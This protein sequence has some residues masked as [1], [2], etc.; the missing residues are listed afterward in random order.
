MSYIP[1]GIVSKARTI[2]DNVYYWQVPKSMYVIIE[3]VSLT[4]SSLLS[5]SFVI[6]DTSDFA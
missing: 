4:P 1:Q 5:D 6:S 3:E 2:K